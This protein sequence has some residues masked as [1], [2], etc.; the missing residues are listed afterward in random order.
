[1]G[2]APRRIDRPPQPPRGGDVIPFP[3]GRRV[4][5]GPWR[6]TLLGTLFGVELLAWGLWLG[7]MVAVA[8]VAPVLFREITS[9]DLAGR[10]FGEILARLFTLIYLCGLL[11]LSAGALRA[12]RLGRVGRLD[13]ACCGVLLAMLVLAAYAGLV[14]LGEMRAIQASLPGPIE[15]LPLDAPPRARFD[16]LHHLSERLMGLDVLLGLA[17]LPL[18]LARRSHPSE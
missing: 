9:R 14:V 2:R 18:L 12:L 1:M 13:L 7:G 15:R 6:P 11:L 5:S 17:L 3:R 8:L 4:P 10:V 16:E